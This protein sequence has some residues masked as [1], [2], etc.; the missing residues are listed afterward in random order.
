MKN[1]V[2]VGGSSGIGKSLTQKLQLSGHNVFATFKSNKPPESSGVQY[3]FLDVADEKLSIENLPENIDGVVYCPGTINLKPFNRL[4][5]NSFIEDFEIQVLGAVKTLQ[6][7]FPYLKKSELASVVLFST[8]AV[9]QGFNFHSQVAVSKGAI[10][11]L[12]RSLAAEWAPHIRVNAIAPSLTKTN[13]SQKLINTD[14]KIENNAER[15]PMKRIGKP[16]DIADLAEFL[17]SPSS[18]WITGQ[19]ISVD[20]GMSTIK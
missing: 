6:Y 9:Q 8:V 20:G 12:T 5:P 10:E 16:E 15:H 17:L 1:Y 7:L 2:V 3:S 18:S 4:K 13:L 14:E 11:G 19:V